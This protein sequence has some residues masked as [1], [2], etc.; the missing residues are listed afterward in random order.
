MSD[1]KDGCTHFRSP[2]VGCNSTSLAGTC[3]IHLEWLIVLACNTSCVAGNMRQLSPFL[4]VNHAIMLLAN[5]LH[6][7]AE[8]SLFSAAE[9]V[10]L[11]FPSFCKFS[12]EISNHSRPLCML[13]NNKRC[14]HGEMAGKCAVAGRIGR[15]KIRVEQPVKN[16]PLPSK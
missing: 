3:Y 1:H 15:N 2:I 13:N 11:V 4:S 5:S 7:Y 8:T 12:R 10:W 16:G 9:P 14:D 6:F